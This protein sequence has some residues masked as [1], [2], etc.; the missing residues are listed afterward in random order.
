VVHAAGIKDYS[1]VNI[2]NLKV[3]SRKP[4]NGFML[5]TFAFSPSP[6]CTHQSAWLFTGAV[7][8]IF[9]SNTVTR[10]L[11]LRHICVHDDTTVKKKLKHS[12]T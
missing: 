3:K 1:K 4:I 9:F 2:Q 6:T 10:K 7:P 11:F 5:L 8:K 12:S